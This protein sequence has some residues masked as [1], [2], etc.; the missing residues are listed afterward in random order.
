M[1]QMH[2]TS[3]EP[4][5]LTWDDI[6]RR[7]VNEWVVL[8][9]IEWGADDSIEFGLATVIGH[10]PTRKGATPIAKLAYESHQEVGCFFT[11]PPF[12][13]STK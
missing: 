10:A 1:D 13:P 9:D 8:V 3:V 5:R 11:G 6:C 12:G 4:E 2:A 7:Y